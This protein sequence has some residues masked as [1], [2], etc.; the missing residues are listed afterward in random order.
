M[1]IEDGKC[2]IDSQGCTLD[3]KPMLFFYIAL[4]H[5]HEEELFKALKEYAGGTSNGARIILAKEIA[6]SPIHH[7]V[8]GQ[9][10]HVAIDMTIKQY[11]AFKKTII[12]K[13]FK[14]SGVSKNGIG[15]QYGRIHPKKVRDQTRFLTYTVKD[16]NYQSLNIDIE[17]LQKLEE[18]SFEKKDL[19]TLTQL[20]MEDLCRVPP[21]VLPDFCKNFD[22]DISQ[23]EKRIV[24]YYLD[25]SK[26]LSRS[27]MKLMTVE[28]LMI[29]MP[30]KENY[31][32]A[33][34]AY[35]KNS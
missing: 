26:R 13:R 14:R 25:N 2:L 29:H 5:K 3:E 19:K 32:D 31:K 10:F 7:E 12:L 17:Q 30:N 1:G 8:N 18:L 28:Y 11:E 22:I 21:E 6:P 23:I 16:K 33:I 27:V 34:Y 4:E 24:G 20:C 35:I 9:H 15:R